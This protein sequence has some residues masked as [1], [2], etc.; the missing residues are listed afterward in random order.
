MKVLTI[1]I[2]SVLALFAVVIGLAY[3]YMGSDVVPKDAMR[4]NKGNVFELCE[5]SSDCSGRLECYK[6][7]CLPECPV[8]PQKFNVTNCFPS[9][10]S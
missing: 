10:E 2:L 8:D 5:K 9:A 3:Y 1:I 4:Y 6:G 7:S